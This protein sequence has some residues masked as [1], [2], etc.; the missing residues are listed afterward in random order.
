MGEHK[1]FTP[2]FKRE[3]V[4]LLESRGRPASE[5]IYII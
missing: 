1:Q 3:A 4:Q 2:G 5:N